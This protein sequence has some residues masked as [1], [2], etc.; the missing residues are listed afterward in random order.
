VT[1]GEVWL[2]PAPAAIEGSATFLRTYTPR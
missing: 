2:L 1:P